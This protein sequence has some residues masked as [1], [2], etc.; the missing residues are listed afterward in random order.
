VHV[1]KVLEAPILGDP[2]FSSTTPHESI[3]RFLPHNGNAKAMGRETSCVDKGGI[4]R[5]DR[6][7]RKEGMMVG[8]DE[9]SRAAIPERHRHI[10]MFLHSTHVSL[11]VSD[12]RSRMLIC[13]D[14]S[15]FLLVLPISSQRYTPS[16]S[17]RRIRLGV[18][19]PLPP[20][21]LQLCQAAD[22]RQ[23][24]PEEYV[25]GGVSIDGRIVDVLGGNRPQ[26]LIELNGQ[27]FWDAGSETRDNA[28]Q[29][30]SQQGS[31]S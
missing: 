26:E 19:A 24:I 6:L 23:Y 14:L 11:Y 25:T 30:Q 9:K 31:S 4:L 21:F 13:S 17:S 15:H 3:L 20:N 1:S 2:L 28:T 22:L 7:T 10:P 29:T 27:W 8:K 5:E 12:S 16:P 18:I